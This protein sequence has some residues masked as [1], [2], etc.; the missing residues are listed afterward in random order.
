MAFTDEMGAKRMTLTGKEE[1]YQNGTEKGS[2]SPFQGERGPE[3]FLPNGHNKINQCIE[4][5]YKQ[6][7]IIVHEG[8]QRTIMDLYL[9]K[10]DEPLLCSNNLK[11]CE[12]CQLF[13]HCLCQHQSNPMR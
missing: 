8:C 2:T 7:T 1:I 6:G 13:W 4:L 10:T 9:H 5:K 11:D 12:A 3:Q